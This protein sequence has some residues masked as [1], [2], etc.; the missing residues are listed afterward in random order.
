MNIGLGINI[1]LPSREFTQYII[2]YR[3][4]YFSILVD[5]AIIRTIPVIMLGKSSQTVAVIKTDL[6]IFKPNDSLTITVNHSIFISFTYKH[7]VIYFQSCDY[8]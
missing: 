3:D 7:R 2:F 4:Y 8:E 1:I 6:I 5:K